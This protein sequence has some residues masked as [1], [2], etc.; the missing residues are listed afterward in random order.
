M[1]LARIIGNVTLNRMLSDFP[2]GSFQIVEVL[3]AQALT[4]LDTH[5][6]R[7]S[8]MPESLVALD[9][10]GAGVG[11]IIGVS[12]GREATMP[13]WPRRV[14]VDSYVCAILDQVDYDAQA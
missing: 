3:D 10:L 9:Q 8:P 5:T 13:F 14:P 12:E 11:Q 1:R 7:K 6:R 2:A 4:G